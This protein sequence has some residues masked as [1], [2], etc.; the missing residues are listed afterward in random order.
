MEKLMK[1]VDRKMHKED[2][3]EKFNEAMS[4]S[5]YVERGINKVYQQVEQL[6]VNINVF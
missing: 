2:A 6:E 3:D 1:L 5:S 4:K